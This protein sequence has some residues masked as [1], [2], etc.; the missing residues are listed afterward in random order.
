MRNQDIAG[1]DEHDIFCPSVSGHGEKEDRRKQHGR[2][3]ASELIEQIMPSE[4][5]FLFFVPDV[6]LNIIQ[7]DPF[8]HGQ[9]FQDIPDADL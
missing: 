6:R 5:S 3:N 8:L 1:I 9:L 4:T 2:R 7:F